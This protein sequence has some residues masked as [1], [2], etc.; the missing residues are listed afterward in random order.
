MDFLRRADQIQY[1]EGQIR[2]V[3]E[4]EWVEMPCRPPLEYSYHHMQYIHDPESRQ[5][6]KCTGY[7]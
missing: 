4:D 3:G 7:P 5:V 6:V 1:C 2:L